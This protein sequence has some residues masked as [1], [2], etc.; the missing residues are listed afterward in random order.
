M[1]WAEHSITVNA[2]CPGTV[3]TDMWDLIDEGWPSMRVCRR[4]RR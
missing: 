4:V 2:Y 1:E 3:G